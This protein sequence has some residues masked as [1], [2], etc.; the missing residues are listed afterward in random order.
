M[1]TAIANESELYI[2][3]GGPAY[4][5]M[6]RIGL[7]RGED[8]SIR[9]RIVAFLAIMW[10]PLF[11]LAFWE[12]V[13]LGPTP[14]ESLLLDFAAFARFFIAVP[15][16]FVAEVTI[17]PRVTAAGLHFVRAG[18]VRPED[19][20]AF[21]QAIRRL[22]RWRESLWAEIVL[23]VLALVGAWT[24]TA[25]TVYGGDATCWHSATIATDQGSRLLLVGL[26]Y[27]LIVVPLIQF[28]MY[29]WL[30]RFIIWVRF[31]HDVSRL[32][33]DLVPTHA[34]G[35]GGLGFLGTTH[36]AFGILAFGLSS[37]LSAAA[38][39][40]IVFDGVGIDAFKIHFIAILVA[41][42]VFFLGP[43]VI[44]CPALIRA[45][46]AGLRQY[47][48]L[49]LRYNRAFHEK[50]IDG[51]VVESEPLLGSADIQSLADLG[52]SF[53]F[54]RVMRV[55]PFTVRVILQLAVVTILPALPLLLLVMPIE[56]IL[57][58]VTKAVF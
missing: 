9:R 5:L 45:R 13:A 10:I 27:H 36:T 32:N 12:G 54:I 3:R 51:K 24:L 6:Q 21:A 57:D 29:R 18:L 8:P 44:F 55:V 34:D 40:V 50:W 43:L 7:I 46:Q 39:F 52:N 20:P 33:L 15:L 42:E 4:R 58:L 19:Y 17:G 53:E 48:L 14:K 37:V 22:T 41:S 11:V 31:L 47:S 16:L 35:A 1:S 49:V 56:Q 25:E 23:L 30:W 38:A 26:W 28:F 2:E